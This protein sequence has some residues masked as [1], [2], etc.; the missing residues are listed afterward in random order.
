MV[1]GIESKASHMLVKCFATEIH[2]PSTALV[3]ESTYILLLL[4]RYLE[5]VGELLSGFLKDV[6]LVACFPLF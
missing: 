6:V 5:Q 2:I 3:V 1:L 4:G